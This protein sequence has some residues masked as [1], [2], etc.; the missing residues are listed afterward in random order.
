M[1][2]KG[3]SVVNR[4]LPCE[5]SMST[6]GSRA[7][8]GRVPTLCICFAWHERAR[9]KSGAAGPTSQGRLGVKTT[10]RKWAGPGGRAAGRGAYRD[11]FTADIYYVDLRHRP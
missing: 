1:V 8:G 9:I 11:V 2:G 4:A 10:T 5:M 3:P 7:G 6:W